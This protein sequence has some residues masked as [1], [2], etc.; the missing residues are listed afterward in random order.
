MIH[1]GVLIALMILIAQAGQAEIIHREKSLY[2]NI[3]V[4]EVDQRRC[5]LFTVRRANKRQSCMYLNDPDELVFS[6]TKMIFAGLLMNP[7]PSRVLVVGLGG[8]S[9]PLTLRKLFPKANID[10]VEIDEKV[11]KVAR[12]FFYFETDQNMKVFIS[13]ARIFIKRAGLNKR[14]YDFI[15]LDAFSGDYIPE[16]LLTV[17]FLQEVKAILSEDGVLAANTFFT[18]QLYD[19]ESE[20][21]R[22]AFG[23]FVNLQMP[24]SGNRMIL[25]RK[26]IPDQK[27]LQQNAISLDADLSR[28]GVEAA[29]FPPYMTQERNWDTTKRILTD[30]YSPANLLRG[31]S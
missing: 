25:W 31:D 16:H 28:F 12:E 18:S 19:H 4:T 30:Q 21:Y 26:N 8:G 5:L 9:I 3:V 14:K 20:T 13:D 17:E 23:S 2:R 27:I 11:N 24:G 1:P 10:I 22:A 6:Y 15:I 7:D 29:T